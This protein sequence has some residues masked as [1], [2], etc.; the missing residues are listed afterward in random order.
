L[1]RKDKN[2][3]KETI[4]KILKTIKLPGQDL[5]LVSSDCVK[6]VEFRGS[7]V[8]IFLEIVSS[9]PSDPQSLDE[10]IHSALDNVI[11]GKLQ[12]LTRVTKPEGPGNDHHDHHSH[13]HSHGHA[14]MDPNEQPKLLTQVKYVIAVASG[15]GGVGKS[16]VASNLAVAFAEAGFRTGLLDADIY[17]PSIQLVMGSKERPKIHNEKI[18]PMFNHGVHMISL[19]NLIEDDAAMIWRGPMVMQALTQLMQDVAWPELDF[20]VVDMPPGT[21]DAQLTMAQRVDLAG[22]VIVTT[23]QEVALLDARKA[24]SMFKKVNVPILGM[25]ENMSWFKCDDCDKKHYIFGNGGGVKEALKQNVSLLAEL[26]L[27]QRLRESGDDGL[28]IVKKD[29][30]FAEI[31]NQ[32]VQQINEKLQKA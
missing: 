28:P 1:K 15:K 29:P 10:Q 23:P 22:A 3:N 19:G 5:D 18:V 27:D 24:V 4:L 26:P 14:N 8:V 20:L 32:I 12:V 17:G 16:A 30:V 2:V 7:D 9:N 25:I 11:D 6:E 21:G 31:F 13:D